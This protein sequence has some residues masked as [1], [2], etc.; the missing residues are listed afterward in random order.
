MEETDGEYSIHNVAGIIVCYHSLLL[1][2]N[3]KIP[4]DDYPPFLVHVL[5]GDHFF[6]K[7]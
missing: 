1:S 5:C 2:L 6:E 4:V 7:P 3:N